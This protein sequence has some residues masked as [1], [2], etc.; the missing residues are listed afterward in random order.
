MKSNKFPAF[1]VDQSDWH[2]HCS[3]DYSGTITARCIAG[4][5]RIS[6]KHPTCLFFMTFVGILLLWL[7]G[8]PAMADETCSSLFEK[9]SRAYEALDYQQAEALFQKALKEPGNCSDN[10]RVRLH[11]L[12]VKIHLVNRRKDAAVR[13]AKNALRIDPYLVVDP[14]NHSPKVLRVVEQARE[15]LKEENREKGNGSS[16]VTTNPSRNAKLNAATW[17]LFGMGTAFAVGTGVTL[18]MAYYEERL[19]FEAADRKDKDARDRHYKNAKNYALTSGICGTIS[20][21]TFGTA[22]YLMWDSTQ[23]QQATG[24]PSPFDITIC[25]V[26]GPQHLGVT[27]SFEF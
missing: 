23:K 5:K 24:K 20:A 25:P 2:G 9:G 16:T 7:P 12:M 21:A 4:N 1:S 13:E 17:S 18:G 27:L 19:Q 26:A 15:E 8:L 11:I 22:F 3:D 6:M 14:F 10:E